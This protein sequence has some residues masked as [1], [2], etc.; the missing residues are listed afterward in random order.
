MA[1]AGLRF[2]SAGFPTVSQ[3]A[4]SPWSMGSEGG[5][6]YKHSGISCQHTQQLQVKNSTTLLEEHTS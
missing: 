4:S 3:S 2:P 6:Y 1:G 5:I